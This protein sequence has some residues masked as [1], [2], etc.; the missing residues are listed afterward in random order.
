VETKPVVV[1]KKR[2]QKIEDLFHTA[3]ALYRRR[4]E[5]V[6][7]AHAEEIDSIESAPAF[8]GHRLRDQRKPLINK[9]KVEG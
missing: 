5:D 3:F 2:R 9:L 6:K 7:I 8:L 4:I 1:F